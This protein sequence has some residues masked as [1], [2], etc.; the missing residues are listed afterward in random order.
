MPTRRKPE[1][2]ATVPVLEGAHICPGF[3]ESY[4][5]ESRSLLKWLQE[6]FDPHELCDNPMFFQ[7]EQTLRAVFLEN[8]DGDTTG[9]GLLDMESL[10]D[11]DRCADLWKEAMSRLGYDL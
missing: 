9:W 7:A 5:G 3:W 10:F 2:P 8:I 1:W 4:R 6:T 11:R